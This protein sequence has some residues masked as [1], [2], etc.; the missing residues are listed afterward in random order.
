VLSPANAAI[1]YETVLGF[2]DQHV[3]GEN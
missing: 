1:W 3:L 2:C